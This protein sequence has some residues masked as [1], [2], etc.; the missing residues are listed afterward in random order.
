LKNQ[1]NVITILVRG[2]VCLFGWNWRMGVRARFVALAMLFLGFEQAF[3]LLPYQNEHSR[4]SFS[5][6]QDKRWVARMTHAQ[7]SIFAAEIAENL[8]SAF[9]QF[10]TII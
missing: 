4:K 1:Q 3:Q 6:T 10:S 9:E 7:K 5:S 8:Q 2:F